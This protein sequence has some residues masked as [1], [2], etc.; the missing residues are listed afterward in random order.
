M[1]LEN[2]YVASIKLLA[3]ADALGW[4]TEGK[5]SPKQVIACCGTKVIDSFHDWK[6]RRTRFNDSLSI[7]DSGSYS[8]MTQLLLSTARSITQN[9]TCDY[10]YFAKQ[11]LVAWSLYKQGAGRT[12][13][14]AAI[15][16][17]RRNAHWNNN[18]F[19]V[20][21]KKR[22]YRNCGAN[23]AAMR[24]LPI[25]LVNVNNSARMREQIF[26]NSIVT[27]GHP[28]ALIGAL[29]YGHMID[30][31]LKTKR[32]NF[33]SSE[34]LEGI[35]NGLEGLS[36]LPFLREPKYLEWFK[37]WNEN[38]KNVDFHNL[39]TTILMETIQKLE[40]LTNN[41]QNNIDVNRTYLDLGCYDKGK[42][43]YGTSTVLAGLYVFCKYIENPLDGIVKAINTMGTDTKTIAVFAAG[44]F[45]ALF[46]TSIIPQHLRDVQDASYLESVVK[47]LFRISQG[48][49]IEVHKHQVN[50]FCLK[51]LSQIQDSNYSIG[52]SIFYSPLGKGAISSITLKHSDWGGGKKD[53][54]YIG[55]NFDIGQSVIMTKLIN[56]P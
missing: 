55:V 21:Q 36:K 19:T 12:T 23:G 46:G 54:V 34:F 18:F 51:D 43:H 53:R 41:I 56:K 26:G 2:R 49:K 10:D 45:G 40:V 29:L 50:E 14:T 9:G 35:K 39:Y 20:K 16:I 44:L 24:I 22:D 7:I 48:E 33:S 3:I 38:N 5:K 32:S 42:K 52:E 47:K 8:D 11:E 30:D 6:A 31:V 37:V 13:S 4:I 25:V 17:S 27:H 1:S 28:R 15:S